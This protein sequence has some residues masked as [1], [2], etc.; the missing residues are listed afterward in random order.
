[1][2]MTSKTKRDLPPNT[3]MQ[4]TAFGARDPSFFEAISCRACGG[5]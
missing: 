1:M 4:P 3:R 2:I 5:G